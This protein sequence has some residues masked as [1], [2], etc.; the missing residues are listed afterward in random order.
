M[1]PYSIFIID[2]EK[3]IREGIALALT[4]FYETQSFESAESALAAMKK[5]L[6]HLVLLDIVLKGMNGIKALE[7][8]KELSS[9]VFVIMI[10]GHDEVDTVVTAMKKGAY[11]Y[12]VKPIHVETLLTTL[13]N[14]LESVKMKREIQLLQE[15]YLKENQ[16]WFVSESDSMQDIMEIVNKVARSL[17]TSI[18]IQGDTGT[19]K[20]LIA[21][22][23]H[24]RSSNFNAPFVAVNCAAFPRDLIE[25]ELFGYEKGAFSGANPAGKT[26]L[27]EKAE[28]GTLF[29]DEVGDLSL[30]AQTKLLRFLESGEYYKVG[31]TKKCRVTVRIVSATNQ[32]LL[33]LIGDNLFR[34]DLY[35]RLAVV[36]LAVPSLNK[37]PDDIIPLAHH[38]LAEFSKKF[39]KQELARFSPEAERALKAYHWQG[40]VRE[41]K[42]IIER[43]ILISDGPV[44]ELGD[45]DL[46]NAGHTLPTKGHTTTSVSIPEEGIDFPSRLEMFET[47]Y[48][49]EALSMAKNNESRAADLLNLSRDTFRYRR[50]KLSLG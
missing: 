4:P 44:L 31:G 49:K 43:S 34:K 27:V 10:S 14:A 3:L 33:K 17:D 48:F 21:N 29:L 50:K 16:P 47:E 41:L 12:I 1:N 2:D 45:I 25:S 38:Y 18:L 11:D 6:P 40:N 13:R 30:E 9:E 42:N 19:G 24:Y 37:R 39:N 8:I 7:K 46:R 36:K 15:R 20:E 23:I 35:Y 28:K 5:E 32:D 22:A 26:G